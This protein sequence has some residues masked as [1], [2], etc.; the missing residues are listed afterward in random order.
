MRERRLDGGAGIVAVGYFVK[1]NLTDIPTLIQYPFNLTPS[2][3]AFKQENPIY[4]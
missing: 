3:S 2:I 1:P 4:I